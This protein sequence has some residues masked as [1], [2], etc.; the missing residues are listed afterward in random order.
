VTPENGGI[1]GAFP[2]SVLLQGVQRGRG[3]VFSWQY[4][5]WYHGLSRSTWK[6]FIAPIRAPR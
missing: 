2:P 5:R 6:K 4:H 1:A 3:G